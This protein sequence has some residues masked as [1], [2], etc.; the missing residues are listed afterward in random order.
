MYNS[1]GG[2]LILIQ[3]TKLH[4]WEMPPTRKTNMSKVVIMPA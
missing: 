1:R 4:D 3:V 2:E